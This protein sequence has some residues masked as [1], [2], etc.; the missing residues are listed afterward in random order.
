MAVRK[1]F[2]A[3][4]WSKVQKGAG[5]DDC[6]LWTG[7]GSSNPKFY[8]K[9]WTRNDTGKRCPRNAH[10]L[11]FEMHHGPIP[12]ELEVCHR[13]DNRHCVNPRHL[14]LGTHKQNMLDAK[15]KGRM[16]KPWLRVPLEVQESIKGAEGKYRDIGRRF[17][18]SAGM[19]SLIKNNNYPRVPKWHKRGRRPKLTR[20]VAERVK[21]ETGRYADIGSRYGMSGVQVGRIKRGAAN[22]F[23]DDAEVA[24]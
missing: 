17:N 18:V 16:L 5:P 8:G 10:A 14:W 11:S 21:A 13:C 15:R 1:S 7:S 6:W 19:V 23:L 22:V 9:A 24:A 3:A 12:P 2:E 20:E 4:F